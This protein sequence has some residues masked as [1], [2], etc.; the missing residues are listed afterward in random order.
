MD[1]DPEEKGEGEGKED[2]PPPLLL[3]PQLQGLM[4]PGGGSGGH[5]SPEYPLLR[6]QVH[7]QPSS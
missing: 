4:H 3:V 7:L 2:N 5:R 6:H 1:G